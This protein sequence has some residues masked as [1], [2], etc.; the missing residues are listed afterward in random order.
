MMNPTDEV[1]FTLQQREWNVVFEALMNMAYRH[2][3]PIL[4]KLGAQGKAAEAT[5]LSQPNGA[6]NHAPN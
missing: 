2:S 5:A 3:A 4:E 1:S 6:D